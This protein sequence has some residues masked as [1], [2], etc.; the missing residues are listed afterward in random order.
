MHTPR[1]LTPERGPSVW[2][3]PP[4]SLPYWPIV[5]LAAFAVAAGVAWRYR[6]FGKALVAKGATLGGMVLGFAESPAGRRLAAILTEQWPTAGRAAYVIHRADAVRRVD[7]VIDDALEDTFPASDPP[8][9]SY[10]G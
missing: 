8:A 5:A 7:G 4:R 6:S 1:N 10:R 9:L 2:A 3:K